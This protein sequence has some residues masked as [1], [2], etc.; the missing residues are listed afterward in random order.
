MSGKRSLGVYEKGRSE[1]DWLSYTP[2]WRVEQ[3]F[4]SSNPSAPRAKKSRERRK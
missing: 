1:R 2:F 4:R 3:R